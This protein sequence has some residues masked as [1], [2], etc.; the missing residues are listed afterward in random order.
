MQIRFFVLQNRQGKTRLS[1]WY[2]PCD[3][4]DKRR[5]E[6]DV[7]RLVSSRDTKFTN[8]VEVS[9]SHSQLQKVMRLLVVQVQVQQKQQHQQRQRLVRQTT[10][11]RV[12]Q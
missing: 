4:A 5:I 10:D 9:E 7:F 2:V 12:H 3:E 1:K 11:A 6:G 8:F